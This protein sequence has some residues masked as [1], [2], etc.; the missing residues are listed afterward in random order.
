MRPI[1]KI[2]INIAFVVVFPIV[3]VSALLIPIS[4]I[5]VEEPVI[6]DRLI[7]YRT[8]SGGKPLVVGTRYSEHVYPALSTASVGPDAMHA[9]AY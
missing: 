1:R 6:L 3:A 9:V 4:M 2:V 5:A 8:L 7:I